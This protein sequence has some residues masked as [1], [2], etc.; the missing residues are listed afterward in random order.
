MAAPTTYTETTLAGYMKSEL[1]EMAGTLGLD[2]VPDDFEE[3]V[4]S[5]LLSYGGTEIADITGVENIQKL[6][7]FARVQAWKLAS[8]YASA[9]YAKSADGSSLSRDQLFAHCQRML[10]RAEADAMQFGGT[11]GSYVANVTPIA[12]ADDPY[13]NES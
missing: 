2:T 6:R 1:G 13:R 8:A 4:N 7:A 11:D 3:A 9:R 12:Y 10:D 5:A